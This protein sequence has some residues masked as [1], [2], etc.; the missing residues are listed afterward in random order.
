MPQVQ[1]INFNSPAADRDERT[2]ILT[3]FG[4]RREDLN[5]DALVYSAC[6]DILFF[7]C[8]LLQQS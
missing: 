7:V 1:L 2:D 6:R 3:E 4:V 8:L 5:K